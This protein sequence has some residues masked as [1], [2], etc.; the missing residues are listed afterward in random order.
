MLDRHTYASPNLFP[1]VILSHVKLPFVNVNS[2]LNEDILALKATLS[3]AA[4][5]AANKGFIVNIIIF[6]INF[7]V[8]TI[9]TKY[10]NRIEARRSIWSIKISYYILYYAGLNSHI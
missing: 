6:D 1:L 5:H 10:Q 2:W 9:H 7:I 3:L 4:S 8:Q